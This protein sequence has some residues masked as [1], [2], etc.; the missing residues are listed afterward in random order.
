MKKIIFLL[1]F[2]SSFVAFAQDKTISDYDEKVAPTGAEFTLVQDGSV[3]KKVALSN[4]G[5]GG[6]GS[7]TT[8]YVTQSSNYTL[9]DYTA[10]DN[11]Q[12]NWVIIGDNTHSISVPTA[13]LTDGSTKWQNGN[14]SRLDSTKINYVYTYAL[15]GHITYNVQK[16]PLSSGADVTPPSISSIATNT[17]GTQAT[18]TFSETL[19][20][21]VPSGSD[22][23][24]SGGK[25]VTAVSLSG[26]AVT[27]TYSSAYA[28]GATI[29]LSYTPGTNK[30]QDL[31]GNL[32]SS[33]SGV[34]VTNNVPSS[35]YVFFDNFN[36]SNLT[37][38]TGR[39]PV[40]GGAYTSVDVGSSGGSNSIVSNQLKC[41][42][43]STLV[44]KSNISAISKT[45]VDYRATVVNPPASANRIFFTVN[46]TNETNRILVT[47][48][49]QVIQIASGTG[50]VL[51][52]G[53][54]TCSPGD[55]MRAVISGTT[56]T[57]YRISNG[58]STT[59]TTQ[60]IS[61]SAKGAA[62][63]FIIQDGSAIIDDVTAY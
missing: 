47:E 14:G 12:K 22:F 20:N 9:S 38:I 13:T 43:G 21:V 17:A 3:Y 30:I 29:T 42:G 8:T 55:I 49:G 34:T 58:N 60:T 59:L 10:T 1:S 37:D 28:T 46:Y 44:Y 63:G 6:G 24:A 57:V 19:A 23:S 35:S 2:L 27:I 33:F 15:N 50:S 18:I 11:T 62:V 5:S 26:T 40:V 56:I 41:S 53:S 36:S 7:V 25:T 45:D 51:F 54:G 52:A 4:I 39:T 16:F 31:A 32:A 48:T 61:S